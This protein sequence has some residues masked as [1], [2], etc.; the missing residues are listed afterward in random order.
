MSKIHQNYLS[1]EYGRV[2]F[3]DRQEFN[4][5]KACQPK[6]IVILSTQKPCSDERELKVDVCVSI[7]IGQ[8]VGKK[9]LYANLKED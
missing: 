4:Y 5:N 8:G 6:D 1:N 2:Q 3:I 7:R 9:G